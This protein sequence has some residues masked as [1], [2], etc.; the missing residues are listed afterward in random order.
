[1][2]ADEMRLG[3]GNLPLR[4][5][6]PRGKECQTED[7]PDQSGLTYMIRSGELL[8]LDRSQSQ[9]VRADP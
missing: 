9:R 1:L 2:L 7:V 5:D 8:I 4:F 3:D 6:E